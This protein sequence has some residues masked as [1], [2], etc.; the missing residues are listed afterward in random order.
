MK[1]FEL[2]DHVAIFGGFEGGENKRDQRNQYPLTNGT[3][4]SGDLCQNDA[5]DFADPSWDE[6][7]HTV[8]QHL[9][10]GPP[11]TAV[12]LD[13]FT[14]TAS[15]FER[16]VDYSETGS[17]R[18]ANTVATLSNLLVWRNQSQWGGSNAVVVRS[19]SSDP[20]DASQFGSLIVKDSMF[21]ANQ[22]AMYSLA[23]G[24]T[25]V[26]SVFSDNTDGG[27]VW[28][29][30]L[31]GDI[32][33]APVS[34]L[35][36]GSRF[37]RNGGVGALK[38]V[39]GQRKT[40]RNSQFLQNTASTGSGLGIGYASAGALL[41]REGRTEIS[42]SLFWGNAVAA[43]ACELDLPC[44]GALACFAADSE[45]VVV[46]STFVSNRGPTFTVNEAG[47]VSCPGARIA[48]SVV[49][50]NTLAGGGSGDDRDQ[51]Y[52][53]QT[54][55]VQLLRSSCIDGLSFYLGNFNLAAAGADPG[56]GEL[57]DF[58]NADIG[59]LRL[60][61]SSPCVD[62]GDP[63]VDWDPFA[64]GLQGPPWGDIEGRP[65]VV[66][67]DGDGQAVIDAGAHEYQP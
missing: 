24:L 22:A 59:N 46:N 14:V 3:I 21:V 40:I 12:S 41:V 2:L 51:V 57:V 37:T 66:D 67:G 36:S 63:F 9:N 33:Q 6:N 27:V 28:V 8:V 20:T 10:I 50:D 11:L 65:R 64:A 17:M 4:L 19:T 58:E 5:L 53:D 61:S 32:R 62:A 55:R 54:N 16:D 18:F 7:S 47:A 25:V 31:N 49:V 48:N 60:R 42:Q 29:G 43:G 23:S 35:V 30:R 26:D 39:S 34:L 13:G 38:A 45:V 56:T 1:T 52:G 44:A 15:N